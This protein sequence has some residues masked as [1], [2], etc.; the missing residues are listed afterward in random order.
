M[1]RIAIARALYQQPEALLADEPVSSVDPARARDTVALLARIAGEEAITLCVSL[2]N[3]ELA[4]EYFPRLIG[5]RHGRIVFDSPTAELSPQHF[6][7]LYE[8]SA[9]EMLQDA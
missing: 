7:S 2:H 8:L 3:L 5:M 6:E 1:Q 4:R 9:V